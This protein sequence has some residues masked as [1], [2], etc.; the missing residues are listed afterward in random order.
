MQELTHRLFEELEKHCRPATTPVAVKLAKEEASHPQKMKRP[1]THI[2]N[3]LA[4]CQGM[5]IART[6]GWPMVFTSEDH[7]CPLP[8]V[9]MGHIDPERFLEASIR[10]SRD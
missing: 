7:A 5:S 9:F 2:G 4:V 8:R 6:F 1:L 3:R 10:S